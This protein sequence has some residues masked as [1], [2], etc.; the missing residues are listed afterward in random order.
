M[1]IRII[2]ND[3]P[4]IRR[5]KFRVDETLDLALNT[6]P[7]LASLNNSHFCGFISKPRGGKTSM[8]VG[9][10]N[11]PVPDG[12]KGIFDRIYLIMGANSR[13]SI[14]GSFFDKKLHPDRIFDKL[15]IE[16][17]SSIYNQVEQDSQEGLKS[18]IILDDVQ[19]Q[20]K[21]AEVEKL[22]LHLVANRRHIRLN[23]W[24]ALQN[25]I[26]CPRQ[27]RM[28]LTSMFLF[29]VSAKELQQ[30][31]EEHLEMPKKDFHKITK[32]CFKNPHDFMYVSRDT[33]QIFCNWDE[34]IY[35]DEESD[36]E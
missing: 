2:K 27:V 26:T 18:L 7:L 12:F 28:L 1:N 34:I 3:E 23:I 15:T 17:L 5:P 36:L 4:R 16:S 11:T 22:L 25:Y 20:L 21:D 30:I 29:N 19:A 32:L 33:H 10:L 35:D 31:N 9:L 8:I 14:K 13:Q 6:H 24:C